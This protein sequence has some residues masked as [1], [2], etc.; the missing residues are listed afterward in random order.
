MAAFTPT[1]RSLLALARIIDEGRAPRGWDRQPTLL[2]HATAPGAD[3]AVDLGLREVDEHPVDALVGTV[4]P[5]EWDVVGC[6]QLGWAHRLDDRGRVAQPRAHRVRITSLVSRSGAE[7]ALVRHEG[8]DDAEEMPAGTAGR[9]PDVLRRC[10]GLPTPPPQVPVACFFAAL[11]CTAIA[12]AA[13][14]GRGRILDWTGAERLHP[15]YRPGRPLARSAAEQARGIGWDGVRWQLVEGRWRLPG[16]EAELA[17]WFDDGS[18]AR[19][20]EPW[21]DPTALDPLLSADARRRLRRLLAAGPAAQ[22]GG[23]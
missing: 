17:A 18:F 13:G 10:L 4:A 15:A 20:I 19:W 22:A 14:A 11:W 7:I 1:A 16:L 23:G 6:S 5:E 12:E 3:G 2:I 21:A 8:G 9:V